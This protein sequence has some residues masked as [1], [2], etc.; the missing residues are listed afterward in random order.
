[1]CHPDLAAATWK[2][3]LCNG[4]PGAP[5][6][7]GAR[8][9]NA[10]CS[11]CSCSSCHCAANSWTAKVMV[12]QKLAP[13]ALCGGKF[14]WILLFTTAVHRFLYIYIYIYILLY[15]TINYYVLLLLLL[16]ITRCYNILLDITIYY[17]STIYYT[18]LLYITIYY[19]I[20]LYIYIFLCVTI[21]IER[22]STFSPRYRF[23]C[24]GMTKHLIYICI[25]I[26]YYLYYIWRFVR[27]I[28]TWK[29]LSIW[30][31]SNVVMEHLPGLMFRLESYPNNPNIRPFI[32]FPIG[33]TSF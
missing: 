12:H 4:A 17:Y 33:S 15:I 8:L 7:P 31:T 20:L 3:T 28:D 22:E 1:M 6:P 18:I 11:H 30:E 10:Q 13:K 25:T 32:T 14:I 29:L 19:Y 23:H 5:A 2:I 21:Y 16:Y 26:Y 9:R 27:K 24:R